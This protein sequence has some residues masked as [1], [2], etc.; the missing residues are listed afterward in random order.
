MAD[1]KT[2]EGRLTPADLASYGIPPEQPGEPISGEKS[3]VRNE[4]KGQ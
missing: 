2:K 4:K 1:T 3:Q